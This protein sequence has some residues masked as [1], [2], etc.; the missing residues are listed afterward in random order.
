VL[1]LV[2]CCAAAPVHAADI[3]STRDAMAN[4]MARMMEA[5]GFLD[6][7][8]P[9]KSSP[10]DP[11]AYGMPGMGYGMMPGMPPGVGGGQLPWPSGVPGPADDFGMGRMME[12]MPG[13]PGW[14]GTTL[15][16]VWEGQNGGLLIVGGHRF[17]LYA[18]TGGFIEGLIQQRGERIALYDPEHQNAQPYEFAQ[19]EG[20]LVLR[21]AAGQ[22]YLYRRL[23]LDADSGIER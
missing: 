13:M 7:D 3:G 10:F 8:G 5:M 17:R 12:Q 2:L 21:D 19:F 23:W 15:D 4:A 1:L 14:R 22:V 11:R 6:D 18:P 20:R 9:A 16:G